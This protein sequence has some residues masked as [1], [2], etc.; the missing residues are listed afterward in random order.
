MSDS[1]IMI[2]K[3]LTEIEEKLDAMADMFEELRESRETDIDEEEEEVSGESL[4]PETEE[5]IEEVE[6]PEIK[7]TGQQVSKEQMKALN[8]PK[9]PLKLVPTSKA[10]EEKWE[11]EF[12]E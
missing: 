11:D 3:K 1:S 5:E 12:R 9:K 6:A 2:W 8:K 4:P 10:E 7:T